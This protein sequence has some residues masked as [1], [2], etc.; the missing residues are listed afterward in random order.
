MISEVKPAAALAMQNNGAVIVDVREPWE[1]A[2]ASVPNTLN[3]P[4]NTI[5]SRLDE[6]LELAKLKS[7]LILCHHGR[8]SLNVARFLEQH[9]IGTIYNITG[10]CDAWALDVDIQLPRY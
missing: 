1:L 9:N 10:G 2:V 4:M 6:L 8:R 3:I 5:P 7:L